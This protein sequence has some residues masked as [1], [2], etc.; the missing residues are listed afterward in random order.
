MGGARDPAATEAA[1]RQAG[2]WAGE[3]AVFGRLVSSV[4]SVVPSCPRAVPNIYDTPTH[5]LNA[6]PMWEECPF[7]DIGLELVGSSGE[8]G[9]DREQRKRPP[10]C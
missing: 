6:R 10:V 5:P 3:T 8:W 4:E 2:G 7:G 9:R 1:G